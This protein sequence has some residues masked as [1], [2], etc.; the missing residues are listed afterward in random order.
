MWTDE[1]FDILLP[2]QG[3]I[4][5]LPVFTD[6]DSVAPVVTTSIDAE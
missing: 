5:L 3:I 4:I 6:S 1:A 2:Y